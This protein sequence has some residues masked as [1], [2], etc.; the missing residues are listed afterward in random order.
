MDRTEWR[1]A[2][3]DP[4][5]EL[6]LK[7]LEDVQSRRMSLENCSADYRCKKG[8]AAQSRSL[9]EEQSYTFGLEQSRNSEDQSCN[10]VAAKLAVPDTPMVQGGQMVLAVR[11]GALDSPLRLVLPS[12]ISFLASLH[13]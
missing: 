9:T 2:A 12:K 6:R 10:W 3:G 7:W 5:K 8:K 13:A 1:S 11:K 4:C